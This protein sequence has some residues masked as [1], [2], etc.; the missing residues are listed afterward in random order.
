MFSMFCGCLGLT[1]NI[2]YSLHITD[3][4]FVMNVFAVLLQM[5]A[6]KK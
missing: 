6:M 2:L 3:T 1:V 4:P 5:V